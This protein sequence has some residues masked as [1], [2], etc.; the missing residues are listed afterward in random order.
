MT[1]FFLQELM[2]RSVSGRSF[3]CALPLCSCFYCLFFVGNANVFYQSGKELWKFLTV[4]TPRIYQVVQFH[5]VRESHRVDADAIDIARG[6]SAEKWVYV[7]SKRTHTHDVRAL[8][9][10]T[11]IVAPLI[12]A[13]TPCYLVLAFLW[14][15]YTDG[16][17]YS[18]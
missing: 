3:T 4:A 15:F 5:K 12:S 1:T 17:E 18:L 8:T 13:G 2:E 10:A 6:S 14:I 11:P 7:G 9:I 16:L